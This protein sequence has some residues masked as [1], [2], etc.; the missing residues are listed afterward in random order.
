MPSAKKEEFLRKMNEIGSKGILSEKEGLFSL[1]INQKKIR[2]VDP[3]NVFSKKHSPEKNLMNQKL[4]EM[5][6]SESLA[7]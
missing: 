5:R 1:D 7:K 6:M 4:K 3:N 2:E